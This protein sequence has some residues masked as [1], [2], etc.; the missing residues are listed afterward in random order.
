MMIMMVSATPNTARKLMYMAR[1][2][3]PNTC[4]IGDGG[5][6]ENDCNVDGLI[7]GSARP[8]DQLVP[9]TPPPPSMPS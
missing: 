7:N 5:G 6:W 4:V 1:H 8:A 9:E 3:S 2:G